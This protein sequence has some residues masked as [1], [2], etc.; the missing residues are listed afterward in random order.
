MDK[1]LSRN[2]GAVLLK[3]VSLRVYHVT[4]GKTHVKYSATMSRPPS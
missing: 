4:Q 1:V 2:F 3:K